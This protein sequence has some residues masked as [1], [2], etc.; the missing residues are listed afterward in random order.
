L[1]SEISDMCERQGTESQAPIR[2]EQRIYGASIWMGD[3]QLTTD[4]FGE[5]RRCWTQPL[6]GWSL[7]IGLEA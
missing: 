5:T 4:A 1:S 3:W 7:R 2:V 6:S